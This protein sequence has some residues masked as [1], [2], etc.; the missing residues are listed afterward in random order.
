MQTQK[1][2]KSISESAMSDIKE[3]PSVSAIRI[4]L[5]LQ[6]F[7][8][9]LSSRDASKLSQVCTEFGSIFGNSLWHQYVHRG[10]V[11]NRFFLETVLGLK[12][13]EIKTMVQ[14]KEVSWT[15]EEVYFVHFEDAY[16]VWKQNYVTPGVEWV[17]AHREHTLKRLEISY[18]ERDQKNVN[19]QDVLFLRHSHGLKDHEL[20]HEFAREVD[21]LVDVSGL[22]PFGRRETLKVIES[23]PG[24]SAK[25]ISMIIK[26]QLTYEL[27][28]STLT[29]SGF[30]DRAAPLLSFDGNRFLFGPTYDKFIKDELEQATYKR[31]WELVKEIKLERYICVE[32]LDLLEEALNDSQQL[33]QREWWEVIQNIKKHVKALPRDWKEFR[34]LNPESFLN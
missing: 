18:R 16:A 1:I 27:V 20:N 19:R 24:K 33:T 3:H 10:K 21:Q 15:D 29:T 13:E 5:Q 28:M 22:S 6:P 23:N 12:S 8:D 25:E 2:S 11:L 26:E 17:C 32:R 34:H 14:T 7:V 9:V 31:I 30:L 4:A